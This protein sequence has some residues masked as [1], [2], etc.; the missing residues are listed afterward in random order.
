[1]YYVMTHNTLGI[2]NLLTSDVHLD[3]VFV[4]LG[5]IMIYNQISKTQ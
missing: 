4:R 1:M 5:M 3:S 2:L